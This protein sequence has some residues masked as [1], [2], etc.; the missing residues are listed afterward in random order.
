MEDLGDL[1]E[2]GYQSGSSDSD[3]EDISVEEDSQAHGLTAKQ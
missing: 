3:D 2:E 1:L